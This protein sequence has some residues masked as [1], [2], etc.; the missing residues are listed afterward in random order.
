M[1]SS[2]HN[3]GATG[4]AVTSES[5]SG[6]ET[7]VEAKPLS[8]ASPTTSSAAPAEKNDGEQEM[9]IAM[10][11]AG[12]KRKRNLPGTPAPDAEVV[13]LSPKTL[14]ATHKFTC[15]VCGRGFQREQ[16]LQLHKRGH[17]LPGSLKPRATKDKEVRKKVY[18]CPEET[19]VHHDPSRALGD[20][21]G[22]KKH[23]CRKHGEKKWHCEKCSKRYAVLSDWKAHSKTCG[24]R[25]YKCECGSVFFRRDSFETHK[26]F[27]DQLAQ[28]TAKLAEGESKGDLLAGSTELQ[29]TMEGLDWLRENITLQIQGPP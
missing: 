7:A 12:S 15:E 3:S 20:L 14:M 4:D 2:S 21:T 26:A 19:C 18:V 10:K 13:A 8:L 16:N 28:E 23:F 22:I 1:T 17:N 11:L 5:S 9:T 24:T 6:E 29:K 27:C 25:D